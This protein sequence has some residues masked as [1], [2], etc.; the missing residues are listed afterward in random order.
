MLN[1]Q[2][3]LFRRDDDGVAVIELQN[4]SVILTGRECAE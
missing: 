3:R 4:D 1:E 2:L